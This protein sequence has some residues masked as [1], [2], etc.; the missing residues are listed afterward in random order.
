MGDSF[1][2]SQYEPNWRMALENS[3]KST[4]LQT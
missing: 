1:K 3:V 4:G 2:N